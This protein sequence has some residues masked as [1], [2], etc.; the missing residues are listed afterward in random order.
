MA[1]NNLTPDISLK[2]A[3]RF[4]KIALGLVSETTI[5]NCWRHAALLSLTEGE[6]PEGDTG[7][8][9]VLRENVF[10]RMK[11]IFNITDILS[12]EEFCDF[13]QTTETEGDEEEEW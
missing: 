12:Q 1:D 4:R 7:P 13:D 5:R 2:E 8:Q 9:P 3:I 10:D 11:S 6:D